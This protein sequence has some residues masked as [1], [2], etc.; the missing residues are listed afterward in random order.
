MKNLTTDQT[1]EELEN[2]PYTWVSV[3]DLVDAGW[4]QREAEGAFGSLVEAEM[5]FGNDPRSFAL[6]EAWDELRKY[7]A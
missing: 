6:D 7:H 4:G 3:E 2:D 5:I 1:L